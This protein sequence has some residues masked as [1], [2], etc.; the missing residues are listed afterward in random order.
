MSVPTSPTSPRSSAT[1]SS[2]SSE[3]PSSQLFS[4]LTTSSSANPECLTIPLSSATLLAMRLGP[5]MSYYESQLSPAEQQQFE[6]EE[7]LRSMPE[8]CFS[9][10]T[11]TEMARPL[12]RMLCLRKRAPSFSR[13]E[14]LARLCPHA[15]VTP[16]QTPSS[17]ILSLLSSPFKI[18][19]QRLQP[20]S[21]IYIRGNPDGVIGRYM[22][23][24][25][26]DD[27]LYDFKDVSRGIVVKQAWRRRGEDM[28]MERIEW[29]D[30]GFLLHVPLTSLFSPFL[31]LPDNLSR[32]F[33][34]S[35]NFLSAY[36]TSFADG[37]QSR[38][39]TRLTEQVQRGGANEMLDKVGAFMEKR[40]Q[41]T[42]E[43][44]E[45]ML[46]QRK[47]SLNRVSEEVER[48]GEERQ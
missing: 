46:R 11:Q 21:L 34:P 12:C 43:R 31:A 28:K 13:E 36:T 42:R 17:S 14:Q 25:E 6:Q 20:Y 38:F 8:K 44:R 2:S 39:L 41:E 23:E 47:G 16:E 15:A 40:A 19:R 29:G 22:E 10:C 33:S 1:I 24:L 7:K 32:L 9:F 3:S 4:Q 45:E 26:W 35:L 5:A 27:G 18:L 37:A 48:K 30:H